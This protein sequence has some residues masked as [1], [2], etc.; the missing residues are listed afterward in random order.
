MENDGLG[1]ISEDGHIEEGD[2]GL[3]ADGEPQSLHVEGEVKSAILKGPPMPS[4]DQEDETG[5]K[6]TDPKQKAWR[7]LIGEVSQSRSG[8]SL[9]D[10]K[11]ATQLGWALMAVRCWPLDEL[12]GHWFCRD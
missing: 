6:T 4:R 9:G 5:K 10:F 7:F 1:V 3:T 12:G 2:D 11:K 8:Y